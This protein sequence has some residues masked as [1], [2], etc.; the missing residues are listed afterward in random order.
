MSKITPE[1][2]RELLEKLHR[3]LVFIGVSIPKKIEIGPTRILVRNT[4]QELLNK[5]ALTKRDIKKIKELSKYIDEKIEE[6]ESAIETANISQG[7]GERLYQET[8]GLL[9]AAVALNEIWHGYMEKKGGKVRKEHVIDSRNGRS[10][11][12]AEVEDIRRW[13]KY[14]KKVI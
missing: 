1:E 10:G 13:V 9:R 11:K 3:P 6:S 8:V 2:R 12:R 14:L 5:Q 7:E 4:I